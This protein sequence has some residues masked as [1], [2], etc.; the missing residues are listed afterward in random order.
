MKTLSQE[1]MALDFRRVGKNYALAAVV[2]R[3]GAAGMALGHARGCLGME[4]GGIRWRRAQRSRLGGAYGASRERIGAGRCSGGLLAAC[5]A[6]AVPAGESR[7]NGRRALG[8]ARSC[9]QSGCCCAFLCGAQSAAH[10]MCR[11]RR[12][13]CE[14]E[15]ILPPL[16]H[17]SRGQ[18]SV[19]WSE[20]GGEGYLLRPLW[21]TARS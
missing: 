16:R 18:L 19:L 17:W 6:V 8:A 14:S 13:V 4:S 3:A 9:R 7:G 11:L 5:G 15:R 2:V 10:T 12:L 20:C 1:I 21:H